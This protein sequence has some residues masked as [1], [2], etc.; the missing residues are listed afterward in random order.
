MHDFLVLKDE[1]K[2]NWGFKVILKSFKK[3]YKNLRSDIKKH[4]NSIQSSYF[5]DQINL[6]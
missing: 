1:H 2:L 6:F 3:T 5:N 4:S